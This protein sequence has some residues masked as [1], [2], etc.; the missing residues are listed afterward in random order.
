MIRKIFFA[1]LYADVIALLYVIIANIIYYFTYGNTMWANWHYYSWVQYAYT[2]GLF[3][4][5]V[6]ILEI[7]R[8]VIAR[9]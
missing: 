6:S 1:L 2:A 4:I 7:I 8:A 9:K 5:A 3:L